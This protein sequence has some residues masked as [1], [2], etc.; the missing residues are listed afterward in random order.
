MSIA[1]GV[2]LAV[3][4]RSHK[5]LDVCKVRETV[6]TSLLYSTPLQNKSP[7]L[8]SNVFNTQQGII[9]PRGQ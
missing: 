4:E 2:T 7:V 8:S 3:Y 5:G 1:L 9:N 6:L